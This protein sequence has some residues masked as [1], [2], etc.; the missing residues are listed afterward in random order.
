MPSYRDGQSSHAPRPT[1]AQETHWHVNDSLEAL[2]GAGRVPD[3]AVP[4]PAAADAADGERQQQRYAPEVSPEEVSAL[5]AQLL[6][7][8]DVAVEGL[9][10]GNVDEA[11]ARAL[12]GV[13]R[14]ALR[15]QGAPQGGA[16]PQVTVLR[17]QRLRGDG[18]AAAESG[19]NGDGDAGGAAGAPKRQ[20]TGAEEQEEVEE[21]GV[22]LRYVVDNPNP[23]N[24]NSAIVYLCQVLQPWKD[25]TRAYAFA[26]PSQAA[27]AVLACRSFARA[28][29]PRRRA[30]CVRS[31]LRRAGGRR[32][33]A[34]RAAVAAHV[35]GVQAGLLRAA[36]AAAAGLRGVAV[37]AQAARRAGPAGAPPVRARVH[38]V[39][40][41]A[42]VAHGVR[43]LAAVA[44]RQRKISGEDDRAPA[45][46]TAHATSMRQRVPPSRARRCRCASRARTAGPPSCGEPCRPGWP[47]SAPSS[48]VSASACPTQASSLVPLAR[49]SHP[50]Q[51]VA[52][53][54]PARRH[55]GA[56]GV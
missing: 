20:R 45:Q 44:E 34:G 42:C 11:G 7:G 6:S 55:A 27:A 26:K 48:P 10:H 38:T 51:Q 36:H 22:L 2:F 19:G 14:D 18:A 9:C 4:A 56:A 47:S 13:V 54:L 33:A 30:V 37:A 17:V 41:R 40:A 35:H 12:A 43:R 31:G 29:G 8:R 32:R 52:G 46:A 3:E 21:E 28:A 1:F 23:S 49:H 16:L 50:W 39:P 24:G 53:A 5:A 15:P 25:C